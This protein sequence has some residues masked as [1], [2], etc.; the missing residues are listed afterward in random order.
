MNHP[1]PAPQQT[2]TGAYPHPV[3][4]G[5]TTSQTSSASQAENNESHVAEEATPAV[6]GGN[7]AA[8]TSAEG[9]SGGCNLVSDAGT[10]LLLSNSGATD[11]SNP[12]NGRALLRSEL[13]SIQKA[14]GM[15][16]YNYFLTEIETKFPK[17][18]CDPKDVSRKIHGSYIVMSTAMKLRMLPLEKWSSCEISDE[19]DRDIKSPNSCEQTIGV[20]LGKL[21]T[22]GKADDGA[23]VAKIIKENGGDTFGLCDT[24]LAA[25]WGGNEH[26]KLHDTLCHSAGNHP[27]T[28]PALAESD[29]VFHAVHI[30]SLSDNMDYWDKNYPKDIGGF[31]N[32]GGWP[33][34][35]WWTSALTYPRLFPKAFGQ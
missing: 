2:S 9:A 16:D 21:K 1:A 3:S 20:I 13:D 33:Q 35:S 24:M 11:H 25:L 17:A 26:Q 14:M 12:Q 8:N 7:D 4:S 23:T 28:L 29:M 10:T 22:A 6:N 30:T 32:E 34:R 19:S 15:P 27:S 5:A 18:F 31:N